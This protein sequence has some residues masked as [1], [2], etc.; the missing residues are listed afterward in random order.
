[1]Y[2]LDTD[3][4]PADGNPHPIYGPPVSAELR[5]QQSL[6]NWLQQNG[7]F[8]HGAAG[9]QGANVELQVQDVGGHG[10]D[11]QAIVVTAPSTA[12]KMPIRGQFIYQAMLRSQGRLFSDGVHP[13]FTNISDSPLSAWNEM[14][15]EN[16]SE[17]SDDHITVVEG[18]GP[19]L[20]LEV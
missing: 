12:F 20:E 19:V 7:N 17:S 13:S 3:P 9:E 4:P 6:Q 10:V 14:I 2:Q 8:T 11:S 16:S 5:F 18:E 15:S 1:L